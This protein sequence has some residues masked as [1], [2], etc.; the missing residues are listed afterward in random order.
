MLCQSLSGEIQFRKDLLLTFLLV[1]LAFIKITSCL[2][3]HSAI[4]MEKKKEEEEINFE[5][6]I[7]E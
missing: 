3:E 6:Q 2:E 5:S 1:E 4:E 7:G